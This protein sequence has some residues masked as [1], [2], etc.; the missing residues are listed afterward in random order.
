[1]YAPLL[2]VYVLYGFALHAYMMYALLLYVYVLYG[3]ALH[4]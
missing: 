3:F 4:A 1:M 2:Y